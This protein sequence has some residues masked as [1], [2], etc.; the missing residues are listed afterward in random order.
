MLHVVGNMCPEVYYG[1]YGDLNDVQSLL[2]LPPDTMDLA[3]N[4]VE[5]TWPL[6]VDQRVIL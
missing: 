5:G 4:I 3:K 1:F 2:L 6:I